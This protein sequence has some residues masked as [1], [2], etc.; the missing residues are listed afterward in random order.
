M[1]TQQKRNASGGKA[2]LMT[3]SLVNP[4][5]ILVMLLVLLSSRKAVAVP[6]P[7]PAPL[8]HLNEVARLTGEATERQQLLHYLQQ[9]LPAQVRSPPPIE[10]FSSLPDPHQLTPIPMIPEG[11]YPPNNGLILYG[12]PVYRHTPPTAARVMQNS[13]RGRITR[14][15]GAMRRLDTNNYQIH[16]GHGQ[17]QSNGAVESNQDVTRGLVA[18]PNTPERLYRARRNQ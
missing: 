12:Q 5:S 9:T 11:H 16:H 7:M 17:D 4:F 18:P 8:G 1:T 14:D 15:S 6:M 13:G 2:K 3:F 10:T